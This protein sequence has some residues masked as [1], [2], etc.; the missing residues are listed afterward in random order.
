MKGLYLK[1]ELYFS[2]HVISKK[3]DSC[4]CVCVCVCVRVSE[5]LAEN[6]LKKVMPIFGHNI[7]GAFLNLEC[8]P[9]PVVPVVI[10]TLFKAKL[11]YG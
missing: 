1:R 5:D 4:V 2:F 7:W 11:F 9:G 3:R 6:P 8:A 10:F